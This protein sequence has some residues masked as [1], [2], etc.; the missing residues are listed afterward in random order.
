MMTTLASAMS[1]TAHQRRLRTA[2]QRLVIDLG[3]LEHCLASGCQDAPIHIAAEHL[4]AAIA[5]LNEHLTSR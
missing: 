1:R 5:V 4:D 3:Y 2:V